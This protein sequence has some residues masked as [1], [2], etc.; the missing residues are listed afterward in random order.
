MNI[1]TITKN[2]Y[3]E[4]I[5]D[6]LSL[7]KETGAKDLSF[8]WVEMLKICYMKVLFLPIEII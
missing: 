7:S 4:N 6:N 3:Y 2:F 8:G 5:Y 1:I